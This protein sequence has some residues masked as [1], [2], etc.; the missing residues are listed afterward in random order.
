MIKVFSILIA[1]TI[2]PCLSNAEELIDLLECKKIGDDAERLRCYDVKALK[3]LDL[4]EQKKNGSTTDSP[5][6]WL[7][8]SEESKMD[9]ITNLHFSTIS[10]NTISNS[11]GIQKNAQL[12]LRCNQKKTEAFIVWPNFIGLHEGPSVEVKLD[13]G[14][15]EKKTWSPSSNGT[16]AFRPKPIEWIRSISGGKRL[17]VRLAAFQRIPEEVEFDITGLDAVTDEIAKACG[18][19]SSK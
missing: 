8:H 19:A 9:G 12:I 2:V 18:W 4:H 13:G 14:N 6:T 3:V 5:S 15:I 16:A 7:R 17:I 10:I 11:I 1:L